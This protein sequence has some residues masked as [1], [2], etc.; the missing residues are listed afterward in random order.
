MLKVERKVLFIEFNWNTEE[1][2]RKDYP[3]V[4][5]QMSRILPQK[6]SFHHTS[7]FGYEWGVVKFVSVVRAKKTPKN[8]V[9]K[10][11]IPPR[12]PT[13]ETLRKPARTTR[14]PART[15][16]QPAMIARFLSL[17]PALW[18]VRVPSNSHVWV[19]SRSQGTNS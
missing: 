19:A 2:M 6:N 5:N 18:S 4:N 17:R 10:L 8:L 13:H 9:S 3:F 1:F 16:R 7:Y 14:Q 15:S 11:I 12:Q